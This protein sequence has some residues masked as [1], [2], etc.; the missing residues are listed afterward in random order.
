M[1]KFE[2]P[3]NDQSVSRSRQRAVTTTSFVVLESAHTKLTTPFVMHYLH[4]ALST[5]TS[6]WYNCATSI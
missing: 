1:F 6:N 2:V 4:S 5:A 3:E